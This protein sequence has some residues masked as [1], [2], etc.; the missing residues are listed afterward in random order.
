MGEERVNVPT[1]DSRTKFTRHLLQDVQA[2]EYMLKHEWFE[3]KT[4]RIGAEQEMCLVDKKTLK[5]TPKNIQ[6]LNR[7]KEYPWA[8]TEIAQFNVECNLSPQEFTGNALRLM[9][10]EN[11][12]QLAKVVESAKKSNAHVV[13]TGILPTLRKF[14]LSLENLTPKPRYRAL[15]D[16]IQAQAKSAKGFELRL[17]GIDELFISHDSPLMEACNTSYQVHLQ[18]TPDTFAPLYN[19][20]QAITGP[21]LAISANS[22]LVFGKR[23]WHE[24]RIALFQQALDVRTTQDHMRQP[25]P[26]VS[27]GTN[28]LDS[29]IM[30]IYKEDIARFRVLLGADVEGNSL[31][32][33]SR[34]EIPKLKALQVHN[35]TVYRWNR[36]CYGISDNGMPH[37]R[38]ENRVIPAGPTVLDQV[39]NSAFWLGA[40]IGMANKFKDIREHMS[41]ADAKDNFVKAA[42]FGVDTQFTWFNNKKMSCCDLIVEELLPIAREGLRSRGIVEED[43]E[44]YLGV[45]EGRA[46]AHQNGARWLLQSYTKLNTEVN[47]DEGLT[48]ITSAMIKNQMSEKPVHTWE[49]PDAK[50]LKSYRPVG[51]RVEEFMETDLFTVHEDDLLEMVANV[52]EWRKLRYVPV[53]DDKGCL[54][55]LITTRKLLRYFTHRE[56]PDTPAQG[57]VRVKDIMIDD[58]RTIA[59]NTTIKD[60]MHVM[61]GEKIGCLPVI[62]DK[63]LVGIITEMDFLRVSGRLIERLK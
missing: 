23:L 14:D 58:P 61:R 30:E 51:L 40:M 19:I 43:I 20:A 5:P 10:T 48:V 27:F 3:T 6:V 38:I 45:I 16:A 35:G 1:K 13:L 34:K 32:M 7:L 41:F 42:Q 39:A 54:V 26:R 47:Q 25:E 37:L 53:E 24:S 28:W 62:K 63:E 4:I 59:P 22:P 11:R 60:A 56:R 8:T 29:S 31:E 57:M 9:E 17:T 21:V 49:L 44:R 12:A 33:V 18:V 2:L 55:G 15:I 36:P 52:M 50:D 46:K